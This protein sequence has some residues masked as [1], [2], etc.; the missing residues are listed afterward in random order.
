M[1]TV[2]THTGKVSDQLNQDHVHQAP[3]MS[4]IMRISPSKRHVPT[5]AN[6]QPGEDQPS[7]GNN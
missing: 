3:H 2:S 7:M 4:S 1:P 6:N 5:V